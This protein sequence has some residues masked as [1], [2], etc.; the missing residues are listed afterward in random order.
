MRLRIIF[1]EQNYVFGL[2]NKVLDIFATKVCLGFPLIK[3]RQEKYVF[4][5]NPVRNEFSITVDKKL[6]WRNLS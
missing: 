4:T 6:F 2:A 5:G 3:K 1:Q